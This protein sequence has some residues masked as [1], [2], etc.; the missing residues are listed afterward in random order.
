[1][2]TNANR[3]IPGWW[4]LDTGNGDILWRRIA[5]RV[6]PNE[7]H[8]VLLQGDPGGGPGQFRGPSTVGDLLAASVT[9]PPPIVEGTGYLVALYFALTQ[10]AAHVPTV[11]I[12]NTDLAACRAKYH[13]FLPECVDGMWFSIPEV[14]D[15]AEAI[16]ATGE[17]CGRR[18]RLDA[19]N[20][21]GVEFG[22]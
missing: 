22:S 7:Q 15:E 5:L 6:M 18:V 17:P 13:Q 10:V 21:R 16:P 4:P 12:Q 2:C 9:T 20:G 3:S 19:P 14:L 11:G 1:M 8:A